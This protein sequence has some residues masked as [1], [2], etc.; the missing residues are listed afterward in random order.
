LTRKLLVV[1]I[2]GCSKGK[3]AIITC[4]LPWSAQGVE[5]ELSIHSP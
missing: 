3:E 4:S 5:H 1:K 2:A